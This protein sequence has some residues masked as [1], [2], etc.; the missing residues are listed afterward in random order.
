MALPTRDQVESRHKWDLS[1]FYSSDE[2]WEKDFKKLPQLL[3]DLKAYRGTLHTS[4]AIFSFLKDDIEY[5]L[6]AD[7]L[8][9]YAGNALQTDTGNSALQEREGRLIAFFAKAGAELSFVAQELTRISVE[10]VDVFVQEI[11]ELKEYAFELKGFARYKD[12]ILSEETEFVLSSYAEAFSKIGEARSAFEDTDV[13]YEPFD[14]NGESFELSHGTFSN[15]LQSED[16]ALREKVFKLYYAPYL[17]YKN[18][19]AQLYAGKVLSSTIS[20]RLRKHPSSLEAALYADYL[21]KEAYTHLVE[22]VKDNVHLISRLNEIKKRA[23]GIDE[24]HFYDNYVPLVSGLEKEYSYEETQRLFKEAI[25]PL[26]QEYMDRYEKH[27]AK[28][29][30]DVME[31]KGKRSGAYHSG[32]YEEGGVVFLNYTGTM[33]DVF[34]YAHEFGHQMHTIF[35]NTYQSYVNADYPIYL[36]EIVS[37]LNEILLSDY[38]MKHAQTNEEKKYHIFYRISRIQQTLYRQTMFASFEA[39]AHAAAQAG[40]VLTLE[41]I[42]GIY[43][44]NLEAFLGEGMTIDKE[45]VAE[46]SRIPH[47]YNP[48]YVYKYATSLCAAYA[49]AERILSG[50]EGA[51]EDYIRFISSG[52]HKEPIEILKDAGVDMTNKETY[53]YVTKKFK[54]LLDEFEAL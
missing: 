28:N 54:E 23:L 42:E 44:S 45:L 30:V 21:P 51:V 14:H 7:R 50:K 1:H 40:E 15:Y 9:A 27:L 32:H 25:A 24:L 38:L 17:Q 6:I 31:S 22:V 41:K 52:M 34:T 13:T 10:Q 46:W 36:A 18:T 11:P 4:Q 2:A 29:L 20:A 48:F 19:L 39:D 43:K 37:T 35:S 53:E 8:Y 47:F 5:S 3:E 26:G 12:H 33:Q 16:R 49:F